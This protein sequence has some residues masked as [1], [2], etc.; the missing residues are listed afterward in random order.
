MREFF[1]S[2]LGDDS[3]D[4]SM[5]RPFR[6][7]NRAKVCLRDWGIM[8]GHEDVTVYLHGGIYLLRRPWLFRAP[9]SGH[10]R[11]QITYAA[12]PGERA[13]LSGGRTLTGWRDY[14]D[15]WMLELPEV[16]DGWWQIHS[17]Y[18]NEVR[19][20]PEAWIFN[21][22]SGLLMY[23]PQPGERIDDTEF[24][25]PAVNCLLH[26][27]GTTE[28]PVQYLGFEGLD[29]AFTDAPA[30]TDA[31]AVRFTHAWHC[32]FSR[33]VIRHVGGTPLRWE[34]CLECRNE[35]NILEEAGV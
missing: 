10:P 23:Y 6:T 26:V 31:A 15:G 5:K 25:T 18:A 16:R 20:S 9:D 8:R 30:S 4:G 17:L 11:C 24:V 29:I 34:N 2:H 35:L 33:N 14:R 3:N 7:P 22:R 12:Y 27:D 21:Q 1:V 19:L 28:N 13:L 32:A